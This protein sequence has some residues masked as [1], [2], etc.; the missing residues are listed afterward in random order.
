MDSVFKLRPYQEEA[1]ARLISR[2]RYGLFLEMGMG[3]TLVSLEA[4]K[5]LTLDRMESARALVV[6]P[7]RVA[8]VSWPDEVK[9]TAPELSLN[10]IGADEQGGIA[11]SIARALDKPADI[12][13]IGRDNLVR[14]W[15][16]CAARKRMPFDVLIL[17]ESQGF[18]HRST[19]RWKVARDFS[20]MISRCWLLTG[21]PDP[22]GLEDLW[23]QIY[24]LD[25][26]KRLGKTLTAFRGRWFTPGARRGAVVY[27]WIPRKGARQEIL[28]SL[29]DITMSLRSADWLTLPD[30]KVVPRSVHLSPEEMAA[31]EQMQDDLLVEV[32]GEGITAQTSSA[33]AVKCQQMA[34]GAILDESGTAHQVNRA[35]EQALV[36][37]LK[38]RSG[39]SVLVLYAF[40][41]EEEAILSAASEAGRSVR[42][43]KTAADISGWNAG[44]VGVAY[45]H[46]ASIGLGLN[47]QRGGHILVWYGL[48]WDL[49]LWQQANARLARQGQSHAVDV[50][51]LV[52]E[53]TVD[54][55]ILQA[56]QRKER[57][58]DATMEWLKTQ[59]ARREE[60]KGGQ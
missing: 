53:G 16:A 59:I 13:T 20:R 38:E 44:R 2:D 33:A 19:L 12:T 41:F 51:P 22:H 27:E 8:E 17:D 34:D 4:L 9:A 30:C 15:N 3:K 48:T 21:T 23:G 28:D 55:R 5:S 26:G 1:V 60:S 25:G 49:E 52:A 54:E 35:K 50:I 46:P 36:S 47:L 29:K 32:E 58:Q 7:K 18:R 40:R 45:A 10:V 6:A 37:L 42:A 39:E 56:L 24:L 43:L 14:L 31:Y 57:A 11:G